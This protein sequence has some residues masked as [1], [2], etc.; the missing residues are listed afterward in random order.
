MALERVFS[1]IRL[2]PVEVPN[3]VVRT[4]HGTSLSFTDIT[5]DVIAYHVA[6]ARGGCGLTILEASSVHPSSLITQSIAT[7]AVIPGFRKMAEQVRPYGMKIFQQL[8]HGGFNFPAAD[9][10]PWAVST[11]ISPTGLV[12]RPMGKAE[13]KELRQAFV[14]AA[15]RCQEGNLDG[16]EVHAAHG[17]LFSQFFSPLYNDRTDEYGG[18][19][20]NRMRFLVEVLEDIRSA[21]RPDF[22][23]GVRMGVSQAPGG[24]RVDESGAIARMLEEKGLID[25]LDASLGDY[26]RSSTFFGTMESPTGYEI[27][28][29]TPLTAQVSVPRIVTGRFRT[30]EEVEQVLREGV[31]D[32]VSMVR[33]QIADPNLVKKTRE[34]RV[35]EVRPCIACNQGCVGGYI[36]DQRLGC[37][38]NAT[39]GF[40]V[41]LGEERIAT[42]EAEKRVLVIGGGPAGME[43]ARVAALLGH[44]VTLAEAS[45]RLGGTINIARKA[46]KLHMLGDITAWLEQEVFRLGVD[47]RFG[48]YMDADDIRAESPDA[49]LVATGS[50]PRMD[51]FQYA[52]PGEPARGVNQAHVVSPADLIGGDGRPLQGAKTAVVF[53]TVGHFE[54]LVTAQYLLERGI[55]V[56]FVSSQPMIGTYV[57]S[58]FRNVPLLEQLYALGEFDM[59]TR[60]RLVEVRK[61]TCLVCPLQAGDNRTRSLD[62]DIVVLVTQNQPSRA[63][64]DELHEELPDV[65][66]IGDARSP[67]DLHMAIRDGHWAARSLV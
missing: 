41:T 12:G 1:P 34:G 62:A 48:T 9:G 42:S 67:R 36:R 31:A 16:V 35:E 32:L 51:G 21:V 5:D 25:F 61:D 55:G 10:V 60:H 7:D 11:K 37:T 49:V 64:Y 44:K 57:E 6:R 26:F 50:M 3:R 8:W 28:A 29:M 38:V 14:A 40:E 59:L 18:S 19:L 47:V 54:G 39:A 52:D 23:V 56:T 53:D 13:L 4:A 20:E 15:L 33:A 46:P 27:E 43:A 65:R 24:L 45:A 17:Y 63:L 22:A 2:G 58:T 66:L 30:L